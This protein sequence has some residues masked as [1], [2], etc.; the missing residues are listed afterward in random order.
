MLCNFHRLYQAGTIL[1][2]VEDKKEAA[3][4][5]RAVSRQYARE[6]IAK[7]R[8]ELVSGEIPLE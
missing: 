2:V 1:A 5:E 7:G 4:R 8:A 6:L 3:R